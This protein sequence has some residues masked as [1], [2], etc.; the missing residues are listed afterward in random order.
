MREPHFPA[1]SLASQGG[2]IRD[3]DASC[4]AGQVPAGAVLEVPSGA[5]FQHV[6]P[7]EYDV[8]H[9]SGNPGAVHSKERGAL[10]KRSARETCRIL[11][12]C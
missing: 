7:Q 9:R 8:T 11:C 12:L 1:R 6:H 3:V 10:R 2:P 4:A 5:V